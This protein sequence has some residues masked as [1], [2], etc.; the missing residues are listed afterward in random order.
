MVNDLR[1]YKRILEEISWLDADLY[2]K[3]FLLTQ[4]RSIKEIMQI[5]YTA[6]AFKWLKENNISAKC[7]DSGVALFQNRNE[8]NSLNI[9]NG[10]SF[11]I[12]ADLL[13][14][15][16]HKVDYSDKDV[17]NLCLSFFTGVE[18]A[19]IQ[20]FETSF[21]GELKDNGDK[22][23]TEVD[24]QSLSQIIGFNNEISPTMPGFINLQSN[25][26][27]PVQT[28]ADVLVLKNRFFS[29]ERLAGQKVAIIWD[30]KATPVTASSVPQGIAA[31]FTRFGIDVRVAFPKGYELS[32]QVIKV[33]R[34]QSG[35]SGGMLSLHS[36]FEQAIHDAD[37]IYPINWSTRSQK[38]GSEDLTAWSLSSE[39]LDTIKK[40]EGFVMS[41]QDSDSLKP[42]IIAAMM[43][44]NRFKEPAKVLSNLRKKNIKRSI[45]Y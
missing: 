11:V 42:F 17:R 8:H 36:T 31:L 3:D 41:N 21:G 32:S 14:L 6:E 16:P 44:N 43:L 5:L 22:S 35:N 2:G 19:G 29:L 39:T 34:E 40:R 25:W 9:R 37:V 13:G 10:L 4:E 24:A 20:N 38:E 26:E 12:A 15:T 18:V 30:K 28:M 1:E 23:S 7:F 33:A 27:H 45:H